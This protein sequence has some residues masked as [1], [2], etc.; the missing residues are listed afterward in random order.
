MNSIHRDDAA[1]ALFLLA[2]ERPGGIFN[3]SDDEPVAQRDWYKD[4]C[5]LLD[6]PFPPTVPRDLNRKRGWTSKRVSNSKLRAR[7]WVPVYPSFRDGVR[8]IVQEPGARRE[9]RGETERTD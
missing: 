5:A 4:V 6:L 7:G 1:A 2:S 3:V 8:A 9:A